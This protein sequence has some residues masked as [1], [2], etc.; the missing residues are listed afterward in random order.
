MTGMSLL[1]QD[2]GGGRSVEVV[3]VRGAPNGSAVLEVLCLGFGVE[4]VVFHWGVHERSGAGWSQPSADVRAGSSPPSREVPGAAQADL[5]AAGPDGARRVRCTFP[6][7]GQPA[8]IEFVLHKPPGEWIK[9]GKLNFIAKIPKFSKELNVAVD[10]IIAGGATATQ[11]HVA[12]FD[13][14]A[15]PTARGQ[16]CAVIFVT[17]SSQEMTLHYGPASANGWKFGRDAPFTGARERGILEATAILATEEVTDRL[18]FVL[19]RGKNWLKDGQRDFELRIPTNWPA[20]AIG[21]DAGSSDVQQRKE[22]QQQEDAQRTQADEGKQRLE[23]MRRKAEEEKVRHDNEQKRQVA[24]EEMRR[25]R[26]L[27]EAALAKWR[28]CLATFRDQRKA[29]QIDADVCYHQFQ[30][31]DGGGDIDVAAKRVKGGKA[32]DVEVVACLSHLVVPLES[33]ALLHWGSQA[34]GRRKKEWQL[35]PESVLPNDTKIIDAKAC[36]TPFVYA[37]NGVRSLHIRVP[38]QPGEEGSLVPEIK[39]ICFVIYLPEANRWLKASDGKDCVATFVEEVGVWK[40]AC[41]DVANKIVEAECDWEHMT[42]MHRYNL[43]ND[44]VKHWEA[45]THISYSMSRLPSWSTL[46]RPEDARRQ[47]SFTRMPSHSLLEID[48]DDESERMDAEF[49]SW[50]FVWQR[51]SFIKVLDWQRRYNTKPRELA[52][53]T[54]ALA[55]KLC[56]VWKASPSVRLWVRWTLSTLGRGG[57]RGQEI[58]DEILHIMHRNKISESAGHFYEQWHQKLHNNTTPDDVGICKALLA[59]LRSNGNMDQYWRVL[60]DHGITRERLASYER[61][62]T[63][64]PY[65]HGDKNTLIYEFENY[66]RI[67]QS[68]HDALD[69]Q[70]AVEGAK[71]CLPKDLVHKLHEICNTA[72]SDPKPKRS[73]SFSDLRGADIGKLDSA[74]WRFFRIAEARL[75]LLGMLNDKRA[76]ANV[77]RPIL[78]LDYALE[79]QQGVLI[80]G[81]GSETRLVQLCD[82]MQALLTSVLGHLPVHRELRV[83]LLDW[84]RLAPTCAGLRHNHNAIESAL[85]LK[86]MCD[87]VSRVVGEAVDTFQ[88]LMGPKAVFLGNAVGAP[89]QV[90][91]VFVDEVLRASALFSVSLVLKRLEP[92]LRSIAQLPPWQMISAV[93]RPVHGE[94]QVV[95]RMLHMQDKVFETPTILLSGAVSGEEEVPMGVQAVLVRDAAS[96]PDILSHCAV[97]ARNS[98]VLLATCFDPAI[99]KKIESDFVGEWVE[100]ICKHDGTLTIEKAARPTADRNTLRSFSRT[101]SRNISQEFL[102]SDAKKHVKMNLKDDLKCDWCVRPD[103]MDSRKVGSK[104]LNL[105]KLAPKLPKGVRTP[106][107]VAMPYGAMQKAL[108]HKV[109]AKWLPRLEECLNKL[110]PS[111]S[112]EDAKVLFCEAQGILNSLNIPEE[113]IDSLRM[114]ME[115]VGDKEGERRLLPLYDKMAAWQATKQVWASLFALRPW[116][117]LARA[118][119]SFHELNMAVLVQELLPAKYAFVLHTK[120]PFT[121]DPDEVYGEIV[122]GRGETLVGNFPGRALSFRS[123]KGQE[124]V[125]SAFLSKSIQLRTQE[126]LIFRSDSNGEDLEGFAGAGLFE[127]V[128]ARPDIP[129][130]IKFHRLRLVAEPGYRQDLLRR[131]AQVG[132][133][134]ELAFGGVAQDIE[135]CVDP[136]D[137]IFIVQSRPQV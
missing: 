47:P 100:V 60:R 67:L 134:V 86:A 115:A 99:T 49:W 46:F 5:P 116:V 50:I 137:R 20:L 21:T 64:E 1:R 69:L 81:A 48:D 123:K 44:L 10:R 25:K 92:Q 84:M 128:C 2:L 135:G 94:L 30:L 29:R 74:H 55:N 33:V 73:E 24:E 136:E 111:T 78:L 113:L 85:L 19:K 62:I 97:R 68:V 12:D 59:F 105:A 8:A 3:N 77:I 112:N 98:G 118:N 119:R 61:A 13:L 34:G 133:D 130:L 90:L 41:R 9:A 11:W 122:P 58:R 76:E 87:R 117:S 53:A 45:S 23:E 79:T 51:F 104:S 52:G 22:L 126:C 43:C 88:T 26:L 129:C 37:D 15:T 54:D 17:N 108:T 7:V 70:M 120:N 6:E 95:H 110:Q 28:T 4:D 132:R 42:L 106:Q 131:I 101:R 125:V 40:G 96:A 63:K 18:M 66:L 56:S 31:S 35:P 114:C 93:D 65:M 27:E 72:S 103:Q 16:D 121:D 75:G 102:Q 89:K 39:G 109:N 14:V 107:A 127:S 57:N 71:W 32:F 82:Q 91:D 36:Q 83:V 38:A 80:Q 124:P